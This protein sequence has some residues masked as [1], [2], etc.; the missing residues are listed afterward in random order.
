[1]YSRLWAAVAVAVG[2]A[3]DYVNAI[4]KISITG[5]KFFTDDGKQFFIK[6]IAYQLNSHDPLLDS[7]QCKLDASLMQT[8]GAN[9]IR[10]Y[11]VDASKDHKGCMDAFADKG[12]YLFVDL[13][14]FNTQI[15]Q[16]GPPHWNSSQLDAFTAVLSEFSKYDNTA[17][18]FVGNEIITASNGSN[19]APFIK[20][21]VRDVKA[22][23]TAKNL[24]KVPVG[25]SA[26]DIAELRPNLQ[27]YLTCGTNPSENIDFFGLNAYEWCGASSYP[28]SGY[29]QLTVNFTQYLVPI[30]FSET[31]CNTNRPRDFADQDSIL[32]PDMD[33]VWSGAII[34]EWIEEQNNYGLINYGPKVDPKSNPDALDGFPRSGTPTPVSPDFDNLKS[35]WATLTPSSIA[36]TAYKASNSAPSCPSSTSG[37]WNVDGNV[38]LPTLGQT[39]QKAGSSPTSKSSATGTAPSATA[40]KT[41]SASGRK[42]IAGMGIGLVSVMLGFMWWL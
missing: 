9:T 15:E 39:A 42:E 33:Q 6:G 41:G 16:D 12:I 37:Q 40:T 14:T 7:N 8:L 25:Y 22:Y 26:A 23:Q 2:L 18:V 10:V 29:Q 38:A 13:D 34:Y 1:M 31:G 36:L 28:L 11:H 32:G 35:R 17:G 20:A 27:N 19:A 4:P 21:A 30:F 5:T 3:A 24:R